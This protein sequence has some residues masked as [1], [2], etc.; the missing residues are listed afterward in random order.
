M[1]RAQGLARLEATIGGATAATTAARAP[2]VRPTGVGAAAVGAAAIDDLA[3][4]VRPVDLACDRRLPTLPAFDALLPASGLRRGTTVAVG[5]VPGVTG[6]TSLAL[7]LAAGA[8]QA[9]SWVAVVGCGS[10]GLVAAA[11]LGVAL[12]RLVLVADPGRDRSGWAP[13]VAAMV[14]GFDV[15]L[16]ATAR[17]GGA[18]MGTG[19][20]RRLVA[21][22]RERGGVLVGVGGD[23]PGQRSALCLTVT[24]ASWQG[25]G[26]GA[27][28][29]QGRRVT[30]EAGGRGDAARG[31]RAELWLPRPGPGLGPGG[32][33]EGWLAGHGGTGDRVAVVDPV[34]TPIP[35]TRPRP[36]GE[37]RSEVPA[38]GDGRRAD[39]PTPRPRRAGADPDRPPRRRWW[40][41][42]RW[43]P[44]WRV[45]C[46][47]VDVHAGG[48][49]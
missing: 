1:A 8:S 44:G 34:V 21:R 45:G 3:G 28:H 48:G 33:A 6:A 41:R 35:L 15:V 25:L 16:V 42:C 22:V 43:P 5:A 27:G 11:E 7:A 38:E 26:Q 39:L 36:A 19:D 46:D 23:L 40:C 13:V 49:V 2:A 9:G 10:L 17:R 31:R 24:S 20:A 32:E 18:G 14:D 47:R 4:R 37:E 12:E 29:L 30:V